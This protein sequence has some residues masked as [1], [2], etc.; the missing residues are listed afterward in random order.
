[1]LDR[2]TRAYADAFIDSVPRH[3][4]IAEPQLA[5]VQHFERR[6]AIEIGHATRQIFP[7]QMVGKLS[8]RV[9]Q[10]FHLCARIDRESARQSLSKVKYS[11][12]VYYCS[13]LFTHTHTRAG[14]RV[15]ARLFVLNVGGRR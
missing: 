12:M 9:E 4:G 5:D 8:D 3:L 7:Q 1:M 10:L 6:D 11:G 13:G 14:A 2:P 15:C